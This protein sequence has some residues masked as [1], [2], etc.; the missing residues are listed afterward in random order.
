M[1]SINIDEKID[2]HICPEPL[3]CLQATTWYSKQESEHMC[4]ECW[5][6]YC[7]SNN[8]EISYEKTI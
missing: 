8:I 2:N 6:K 1:A 4:Y 7:K 5:L 3:I